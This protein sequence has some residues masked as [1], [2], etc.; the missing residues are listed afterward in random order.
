MAQWHVAYGP[1]GEGSACRCDAGMS[2][3]T[4]EGVPIPVSAAPTTIAIH[5]SQVFNC[6]NGPEKIE[7]SEIQSQYSWNPF[8][9]QANQEAM[10]RSYALQSAHAAQPGTLGESYAYNGVPGQVGHA[11][12]AN[13]ASGPTH[14]FNPKEGEWVKVSDLIREVTRK[15]GAAIV[16]REFEPYAV[17]APQKLADAQ[18]P[19]PAR[20]TPIFGESSLSDLRRGVLA[21][22]D[23][24]RPAGF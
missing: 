13:P 24:F 9:N 21:C 20:C 17:T 16:A 8:A 22:W 15:A 19:A 6:I 4:R 11:S 2:H 3:G 23:S 14:V 18:S 7:W 10:A 12:A 1:R 5:Q